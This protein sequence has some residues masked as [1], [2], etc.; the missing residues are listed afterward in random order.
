MFVKSKDIELAESR[1]KLIVTIVL[2][3]TGKFE[4]LLYIKREDRK[5]LTLKDLEKIATPEFQ[6]EVRKFVMEA[7]NEFKNLVDS[8]NNSFNSIL[9]P[10]VPFLPPETNTKGYISPDAVSE[11]KELS[12]I[13]NKGKAVKNLMDLYRLFNRLVEAFP[14]AQRRSDSIV[15]FLVFTFGALTFTRGVERGVKYRSI[16]FTVGENPFVAVIRYNPRG[17]FFNVMVVPDTARPQSVY[18]D[19]ISRKKEF[20]KEVFNEMDKAISTSDQENV[21][22]VYERYREEFKEEYFSKVDKIV[23]IMEEAGL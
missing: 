11:L 6:E 20:F 15:D 19:I 10:L 23:A 12:K 7:K 5:D 17:I 1:G 22:K 3:E 13:K 4:A 21:K 16:S 14:V 18:I 8:L 9:A 2:K